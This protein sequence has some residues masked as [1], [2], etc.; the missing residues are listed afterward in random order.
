MAVPA[1]IIGTS[2]FAGHEA[3]K[4]ADK[5]VQAQQE[6]NQPTLDYQRFLLPYQMQRVEETFPLEQNYLTNY[7]YPTQEKYGQLV[8]SLIPQYTDLLNRPYGVSDDESNKIF[9]RSRQRISQAYT[10]QRQGAG[11][12]L[13]SQGIARG[14]T[15]E[16]V[17]RDI[18][19][20]Q[21]QAET[22]AAV[23]QAIYEAQ[24]KRIDQERRVAEI[25][26]LSGVGYVQPTSQLPAQPL[27]GLQAPQIQQP[28]PA[29]LGTAAAK[30]ANLIPQANTVGG[31]PTIQG[32][33]GGTAGITNVGGNI[34][35]VPTWSPYPIIAS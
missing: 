17:M 3:S 13:A 18:G 28:N 21:A 7:Y 6:I 27:T 34:G 15:Y 9:G 31:G 14:G 20:N 5:Q 24:Q 1:A 10:Q 30:L 29:A 2:L 35:V 33:V 8:Q 16:D 4:A 26:A 11:E 12:R 23:D 32:G 25:G 22:Q 19:L